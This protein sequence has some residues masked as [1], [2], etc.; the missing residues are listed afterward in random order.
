MILTRNKDNMYLIVFVLE[1]NIHNSDLTYS[2]G[3]YLQVPL[4]RPCS[5]FS[6]AAFVTNL[7]TEVRTPDPAIKSFM[8]NEFLELVALKMG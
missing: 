1:S 2:R 3:V 4:R 5:V 8:L 6:M 7:K